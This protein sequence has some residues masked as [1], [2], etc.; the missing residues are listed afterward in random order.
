MSFEQRVTISIYILLGGLALVIMW[1]GYLEL[2]LQEI[3]KKIE[4][5]LKDAKGARP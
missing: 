5:H 1:V 4:R 3:M 2:R